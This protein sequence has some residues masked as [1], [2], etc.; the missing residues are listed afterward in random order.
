MYLKKFWLFFG[1]LLYYII[2]CLPKLSQSK[3]LKIGGIKS[4]ETITRSE[5]K[6]LHKDYKTI[7]NKQK[8]VLK[9]SYGGAC[10]VPVNVINDKEAKN[11]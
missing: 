11:G 2:R 8:Y 10:L 5:W 3:N 4:M 1:K 9:L 6:S 7:I